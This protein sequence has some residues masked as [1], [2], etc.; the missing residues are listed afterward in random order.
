M[1]KLEKALK[2]AISARNKKKSEAVHVSD[3]ATMATHNPQSDV[4]V[5]AAEGHIPAM[6]EIDIR[7]KSQL[8]NCELIYPDMSNAKVIDQFREIRTH[9]YQA[10]R[11]KNC[12]ILVTSVAG[13]A[14]NTFVT[15][16]IAAAIAL[17]DSKTSLVV[18][19]N[20]TNPGFKNLLT[21]GEHWG[22]TDY[23]EGNIS[24]EEII[25]PIGIQRMR[26]ISAG[27]KK[28]SVTDYLT[29]SRLKALFTELQ[30]RFSDRVILVDSP[31]IN[32]SADA[33][34][35]TDL[36]SHV[37]LVVP[38]RKVNEA[39]IINAIKAIGRE[40]IIGLVINKEPRFLSLFKYS[41]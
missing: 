20:L 9:I 28:E 4:V 35:L 34:M 12:P 41:H 29:S 1:S 32:D 13:R 37:I 25:Q 31:S 8:E 11:E 30:E 33:K 24:L 36:F 27:A 5:S 7:T 21:E 14:G 26:L 17:D 6:R 18:D 10:L 39:K 19:C 15:K 2:N 3:D 40:K 16:N 22:V 38:Y 23:I